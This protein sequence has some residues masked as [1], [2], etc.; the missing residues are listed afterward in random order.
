MKH[1]VGDIVKVVKLSNEDNS[2][3][4]KVGDKGKIV[5]FYEDD[6]IIQVIIDREVKYGTNNCWN[7]DGSYD[8]Y[9]WQLEKV[10]EKENNMFTKNDLKVGDILEQ[11]DGIKNIYLGKDEMPVI[12]KN[13]FCYNSLSN[14]D[15]NLIYNKNIR[16]ECNISKV[17]RQLNNTYECIWDRAEQE[18]KDEMLHKEY[19]IEQIDSGEECPNKDWSIKISP[20]GVD[21]YGKAE[22]NMEIVLESLEEDEQLFL[23]ID[24]AKELI[25][26]LN[27]II[28]YVEGE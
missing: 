5:E 16:E 21:G 14:F 24:G 28:D 13:G 20:N 1:K 25:E 17:Y 15:E 8:F 7:D 3:D 9:D 27:E 19:V 10:E 22:G 26:H 6:D 11:Y 23:S 4:L 18:K 12:Y 2:T